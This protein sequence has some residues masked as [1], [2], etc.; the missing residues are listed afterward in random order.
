MVVL[1]GGGGFLWARYPCTIRL[2][3]LV[4]DLPV[5]TLNQN[6]ETLHPGIDTKDV[7]FVIK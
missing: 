1:G 4:P 3:V 7:K 6:P 5:L 2:G